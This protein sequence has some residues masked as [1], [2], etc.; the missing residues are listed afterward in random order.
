[1][2]ITIVGTEQECEL[3][4]DALELLVDV[5]EHTAPVPADDGLVRVE[6]VV[7]EPCSPGF[8]IEYPE[9]IQYPSEPSASADKPD[10]PPV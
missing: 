10:R 3:A 5:R 6:A 7:I 4:I 1:M 8:Y 9:P 2:R